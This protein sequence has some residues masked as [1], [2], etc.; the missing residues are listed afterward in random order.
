MHESEENVIPFMSHKKAVYLTSRQADI[1]NYIN[2]N[3]PKADEK[4]T[5]LLK[6]FAPVDDDGIAF[7]NS[8][9]TTLNERREKKEVD[10]SNVIN[11]KTMKRAS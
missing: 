10:S 6:K 3:N 5:I 1:I 2:Q 4:A 7:F 9:V 8:M 11:F